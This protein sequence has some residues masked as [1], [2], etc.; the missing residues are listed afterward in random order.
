MNGNTISAP[1]MKASDDAGFH[2]EK[3]NG[4][5]RFWRKKSRTREIFLI[6]F[7]IIQTTV[8]YIKNCNQQ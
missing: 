3:E 5:K 2:S 6:D 1:P 7:N 4:L 8:A